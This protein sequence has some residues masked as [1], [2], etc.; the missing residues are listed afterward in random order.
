LG[1]FPVHVGNSVNLTHSIAWH[2]HISFRRCCR[3]DETGTHPDL[4]PRLRFEH[5]TLVDILDDEHRDDLRVDLRLDIVD[6]IDSSSQVEPRL[7]LDLT[8]V[9]GGSDTLSNILEFR[10]LTSLIAQSTSDSARLI[11][12]LG[13]LHPALDFH[14]RT[15]KH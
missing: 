2:H 10:P 4:L 11:F 6:G 12:P 3:K 14:P 9:S 7:L 5:R 8:C 15:I 13:K 1:R